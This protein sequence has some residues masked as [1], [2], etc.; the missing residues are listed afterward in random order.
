MLDQTHDGSLP[1]WDGLGAV[2]VLGMAQHDTRHHTH[3]VAAWLSV[4]RCSMWLR[5]EA[6]S[7]ARVS[8]MPDKQTQRANGVSNMLKCFLPSLGSVAAAWAA[9]MWLNTA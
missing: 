6:T 7:A 8:S 5:A 1:V 3:L 4:V 9:G 2:T